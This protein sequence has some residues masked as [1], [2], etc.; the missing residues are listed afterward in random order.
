[1]D[2]PF[3][4]TRTRPT[5]VQLP[6]AHFPGP[7]QRGINHTLIDHLWRATG[8]TAPTP[9]W[10][11]EYWGTRA[12]YGVQDMLVYCQHSQAGDKD[13]WARACGALSPGS[14]CELQPVPAAAANV[15]HNNTQA[16]LYWRDAANHSR[17]RGWFDRVRTCSHSTDQH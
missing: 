3:G 7:P 8:C 12:D 6:N 13:E 15:T 17:R 2:L 11:Y 10:G 4:L 9:G 16:I 1:M 5:A 14:K